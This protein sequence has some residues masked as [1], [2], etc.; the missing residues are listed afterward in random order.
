ME[1]KIQMF[2][3][4]NEKLTRF[5]FIVTQIFLFY[6]NVSSPYILHFIIERSLYKRSID[7]KFKYQIDID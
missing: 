1:T 5:N 4:K 3:D 6:F 2:H 7:R